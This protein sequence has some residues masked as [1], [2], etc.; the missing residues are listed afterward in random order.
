MR[1]LQKRIIRTPSAANHAAL[2]TFMSEVSTQ[3]A[4]AVVAGVSQAVAPIANDVSAMKDVLVGDRRPGESADSYIARARL[5]KRALEN[6]IAAAV[7]EQKSSVANSHKEAVVDAVRVVMEEKGYNPET[8][9]EVMKGSE[10]LA[11][12]AKKAEEH[13]AK[14]EKDRELQKKKL[15][16][17]LAAVEKSRV[18]AQR[19]Y[20]AQNAKADTVRG[21]PKSAHLAPRLQALWKLDRHAAHLAEQLATLGRGQPMG[22]SFEEVEAELQ[23]WSPSPAEY[24]Q[25]RFYW[26]ELQHYVSADHPEEDGQP[27]WNAWLDLDHARWL[28]DRIFSLNG[29]VLVATMSQQARGMGVTMLQRDAHRVE[30]LR[31]GRWAA[32]VAHNS[33]TP[34]NG[35]AVIGFFENFAAVGVSQAWWQRLWEAVPDDDFC[36]YAFELRALALQLGTRVKCP[37]TEQAGKCMYHCVAHA[38]SI[39]RELVP[40]T[41]VHVQGADHVFMVQAL[42]ACCRQMAGW[43]DGDVPAPPRHNPGNQVAAVTEMKAELNNL[44]A[45]LATFARATPPSEA[46]AAEVVGQ[47]SEGVDGTEEPAVKKLKAGALEA[48]GEEKRY[49]E[50]FVQTR[51][52]SDKEEL[53]RVAFLRKLGENARYSAEANGT[54]IMVQAPRTLQQMRVAV[55]GKLTATGWKAT[56]KEVSAEVV[57]QSSAAGPAPICEVANL[58]ICKFANLQSLPYK[59]K[60]RHRNNTSVIFCFEVWLHISFF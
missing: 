6:N 13:A 57:S 46:P 55:S 29:L 49:Y 32:V 22:D 5:Q 28:L 19:Q 21:K 23:L 30:D 31:A 53:A 51:G 11:E 14:N 59:L 27:P 15:E 24:E 1:R 40:P 54:R 7:K 44:V 58:Q 26:R 4:E 3:L 17:A 2:R 48:G 42:R 52:D 47:D 34:T 41:P 38:A 12:A 33:S 43:Q 16:K 50:I 10:V 25:F 20:D 37:R 39:L 56:V 36:L 18:V 9:D 8:V 35:H 60:L 45:G